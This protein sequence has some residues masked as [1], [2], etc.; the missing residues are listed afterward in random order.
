MLIQDFYQIEKLDHNEGEIWCSIVLNQTHEVYKGHFPGQPVVPGV[1]QLQMIKEILEQ[2]FQQQLFLKQINLAK[3]LQPIDPVLF[4][5][6]EITI[7]FS[8][9]E[10]SVYKINALIL[11]KEVTF[12][13]IRALVI[14]KV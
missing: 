7:D 4:S 13:K 12:S 8:L 11:A 14:R 9:T 5:E 6:L 3:Y 1:I 10:E 2:S